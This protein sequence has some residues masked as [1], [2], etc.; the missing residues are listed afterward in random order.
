MDNI[1][2]FSPHKCTQDRDEIGPERI[3]CSATF[4]NQGLSSSLCLNT[5]SVPVHLKI[6]ITTLCL[7]SGARVVP[8]SVVTVKLVL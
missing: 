6:G 1:D 3:S 2:A 8:L 5:T 7:F 4:L